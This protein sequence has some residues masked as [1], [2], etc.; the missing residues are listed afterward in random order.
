[1]EYYYSEQVY[2][3]LLD[4]ADEKVSITY[5]SNLY[6]YPLPAIAVRPPSFVHPSYTPK[7]PKI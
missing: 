4:E 5:D 2:W 3:L 7:Y 6:P 1:M